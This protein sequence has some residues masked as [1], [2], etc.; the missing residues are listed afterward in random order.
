MRRA[1]HHHISITLVHENDE[2]R[3]GCPFSRFFQTTPE[4]LIIDHALYSSI[5]VACHPEPFRPVSHALS[6]KAFG[7][8]EMRPPLWRGGSTSRKLPLTGGQTHA[9]R[10]VLRTPSA[11]VVPERPPSL[12]VLPPSVVVVPPQAPADADAGDDGMQVTELD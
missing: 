8:R 2:A 3:G 7:A 9:K 6:A 12:E 11:R 1:R 5:A 4:D 10:S